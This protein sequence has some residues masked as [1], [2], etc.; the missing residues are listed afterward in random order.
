VD[1]VIVGTIT[2]DHLTPADAV[3]V[4]RRLAAVEAVLARLTP[5]GLDA[6]R[7]AGNAP[8]CGRSRM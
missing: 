3:S 2:P 4:I 1:G 6:F 5:G 8:S 7:R